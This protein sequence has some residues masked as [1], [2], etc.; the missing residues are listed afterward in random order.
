MS[1]AELQLKLHQSIDSITDSDKL[2]ALYIQLKGSEPP[3]Q[4]MDLKDDIHAIDEAG[5]QIKK[6]NLNQ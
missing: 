5:Q 4:P 3:F 2:K 6:G 1:V